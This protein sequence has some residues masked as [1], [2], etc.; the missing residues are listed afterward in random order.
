MFVNSGM[1]M[2]LAFQNVVRGPIWTSLPVW[3]EG[4]RPHH[5][6]WGPEYPGHGPHWSGVPHHPV[7]WP[8]ADSGHAPA[9]DVNQK[10]FLL[11]LARWNI[12]ELILDMNI[13]ALLS[14]KVYL[15]A[16]HYLS[17]LWYEKFACILDY[18]LGAL[19]I[20]TEWEKRQLKLILINTTY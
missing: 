12:L 19:I 13:F 7:T 11:F 5:P 3:P 4:E 15:T 20:A 2:F 14:W 9:G 10:R 18:I 17:I 8:P 16:L 1:N 6:H